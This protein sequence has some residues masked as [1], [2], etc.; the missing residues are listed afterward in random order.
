MKNYIYVI[1]GGGIFSRFF[2]SCLVPLA[3]KDFDN[4]FLT[5]SPFEE[6]E[7]TDPVLKEQLKYILHHRS[8]MQEYGI[9]RPYDHIMGYVLNQQ[10]DSSYIYGGFLPISK[11]YDRNNPIESSSRLQE[12]K[13][14]LAKIHIKNEIKN[15]VDRFCIQNNVGQKTLG[16][17]IRMTTMLL[18]K[19]HKQISYDDYCTLIDA[20]L[21]TGQYD[22][23]YVASDNDE[24]LDKLKTRYGKYIVCYENLI[25]MKYEIIR[26][27]SGWSWEYDMFYRKQFWQESFTECMTLSRCGAMICRDSNFSNMA[28]VFSNTLKNIYRP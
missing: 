18:H 20:C 12:Y 22:N 15:R 8:S 6:F 7:Q 5:L 11:L 4:V 19:N 1:P 27:M 25:R 2:Q 16:V 13:N 28:V 21:S 26:D 17:H 23:M 10:T 9:E 14:T 24:S 3:D